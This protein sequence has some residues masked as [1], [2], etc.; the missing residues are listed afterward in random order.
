[1]ILHPRQ[2]VRSIRVL[3]PLGGNVPF[4]I[5]QDILDSLKLRVNG[6]PVPL[7]VAS[8]PTRVYEAIL[9]PEVLAESSAGM[10]LEFSVNRTVV[11]PGGNRTLAVA[12]RGLE[13]SEVEAGSP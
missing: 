10:V 8:A 4:G 3:I 9:T 5:E 13:F 1:M 11:P 7:T 6:R 12:F 2:Q